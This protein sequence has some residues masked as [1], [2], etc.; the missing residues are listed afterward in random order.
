MLPAVAVMEKRSA[1]IAKGLMLLSYARGCFEKAIENLN[2]DAGTRSTLQTKQTP[3]SDHGDPE[4][5][6][7]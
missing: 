7:T 2:L 1:V 3:Q 5:R 6:L 4:L